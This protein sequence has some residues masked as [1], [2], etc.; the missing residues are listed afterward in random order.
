MKTRDKVIELRKKGKTYNEISEELNI[1]KS[2][3]GYHC[4]RWNLNEIG[5][6]NKKL[7]NKLID[8]I[9]KYY[10]THTKKET[11]IKFD[12]SES[13]VWRYTSNKSV[14]LTD[15]EIRKNRINSVI[16]WRRR[17]KI[18]LVDYKGGEC[19]KCGYKKCISSLEF[20]HLD[21]N[22][23]DFSIS[24]KSISFE[25]LKKEVDK[26]ILVCRNCHGEIHH[27]IEEEKRRNR[28]K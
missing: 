25:R 21:P 23:K 20:H 7:D 8:E 13:T 22:E 12:I 10:K 18:K 1:S 26:C 9:K 19:E 16:E 15:E 24:G 14:K 2:T 3:I 4:K 28:K 27:E 17:V 6:G 5:L 11:A